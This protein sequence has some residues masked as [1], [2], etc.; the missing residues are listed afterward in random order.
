MMTLPSSP[1]FF[2][3]CSIIDKIDEDDDDSLDGKKDVSLNQGNL[4][5]NFNNFGIG[6]ITNNNYNNNNYLRRRRNRN[7]NNYNDNNNYSHKYNDSNNDYNNNSNNINMKRIRKEERM[8]KFNMGQAYVYEKCLGSH[9]FNDVIC[10]FILY[11]I[12]L[13][14]S[15]INEK[16]FY[17]DT[18][19]TS[20]EVL[21]TISSSKIISFFSLYKI[22]NY[23]SK[24]LIKYIFFFILLF[25]IICSYLI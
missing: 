10:N 25:Y 24:T 5:L 16:V 7:R 1:L 18:S 23:I 8:K 22:S 2:L 11:I 14:Y 15:L 6:N 21:P 9:I 17:S 20:G 4:N 19:Q 3:D 13:S 12:N